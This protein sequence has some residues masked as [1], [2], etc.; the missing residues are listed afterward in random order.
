MWTNSPRDNSCQRQWRCSPA[1]KSI[2]HGKALNSDPAGL[3]MKKFISQIDWMKK[4]NIAIPMNFD[5]DSI[6][7]PTFNLIRQ[8]NDDA[9]SEANHCRSFFDSKNVN[10]CDGCDVCWFFICYPFIFT[11]LAFIPSSQNICGWNTGISVCFNGQSLITV[12]DLHNSER[13]WFEHFWFFY[14]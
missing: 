14:L 9:T 13:R 4:R 8:S 12:W 5:G 11:K 6:C 3:K 1:A 10:G 2:I 7:I